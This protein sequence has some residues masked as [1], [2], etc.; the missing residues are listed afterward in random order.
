MTVDFNISKTA[1]KDFYV[2]RG[3][4]F[5]FDFQV[6]DQD[7][8]AV[9]LSDYTSAKMQV[10][11]NENA[12]SVLTLTS[13]GG[14][15]DISNLDSGQIVLSASTSSVVANTYYYDLE[16]SNTNFIQTV[17]S[18]KMFVDNDYTR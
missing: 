15:I 3:D 7:D 16:L 8:N 17:M 6:L 14:T 10:K 9:D 4:T 12:T 18:G 5:Y 11:K 2:K 13:S 1:I